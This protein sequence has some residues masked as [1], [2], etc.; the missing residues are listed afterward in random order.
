SPISLCRADQMRPTAQRSCSR[1]SWQWQL[2]CPALLCLLRSLLP[3][4]HS[5]NGRNPPRSSRRSIST[6]SPPVALLPQT[7]GLEA[8]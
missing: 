5:I 8:A 6:L 1:R 3:T 4:I 2:H 7:H